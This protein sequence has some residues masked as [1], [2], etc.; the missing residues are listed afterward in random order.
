MLEYAA[1]ALDDA[2]ICPY[3]ELK[4]CRTAVQAL[5]FATEED[6]Q[7]DLTLQLHISS[8]CSAHTDSP[9]HGGNVLTP[10]TTS[11]LY[12]PFVAHKLAFY[13]RYSS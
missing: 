13:S 7:E 6:Q 9:Q 11:G 4:E 10:K 2:G 3:W 1:V 8:M 5:S 12:K